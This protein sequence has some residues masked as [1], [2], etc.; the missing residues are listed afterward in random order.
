MR[1][2]HHQKHSPTQQFRDLRRMRTRDRRNLM[3]PMSIVTCYPVEAVGQEPF[4]T[5]IKEKLTFFHFSDNA[6]VPGSVSDILMLVKLPEQELCG[7]HWIH[8]VCQ[9]QSVLVLSWSNDTQHKVSDLLHWVPA[10]TTNRTRES[11]PHVDRLMVRD[12]CSSMIDATVV[13][14]SHHLKG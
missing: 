7:H 3:R 14:K 12:A 8:S 13:Q 6:T 11:S 4:W 10:C 2:Y 1:Y 5:R 9:T